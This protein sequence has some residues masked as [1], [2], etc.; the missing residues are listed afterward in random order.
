MKSKLLLSSALISAVAFTGAVHAETKVSGDLEQTYHSASR[1]LAAEDINGASGFGSE[2]NISLSSSK[3]LDN[4]LALKFGTTLEAGSA[5]SEYLTISGDAVEFTVGQDRGDSID[6]DVIPFISDDTATMIGTVGGETGN[7]TTAH[8]KHHAEVKA[9]FAGSALS[10]RYAPSA[11]NKDA[12]D[13]AV[14][15]KDAGGSLT[16]IVL[17]GSLG[18]EGLS[19]LAG[20]NTQVQADDTAA[21]TD[22]IKVTKYGA[23]YNFGQFTVG[24]QRGK[25]DD[26]TNSATDEETTDIYGVSFA[27]TDNL[28]IGVYVSEN[29][30]NGTAEDEESKMLQ[31]GYN[32]G[33]LGIEF[34]AMQVEN[35]GFT[36]GD[37]A[38]V[39]MI[40][41][42]QKF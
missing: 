10:V 3:D 12:D 6:G 30:R 16:E 1:D 41:T 17:K 19:V 37:D 33:G 29:D 18:V 21:G 36:S 4:G 38:D 24:A 39:Y 5:D 27:A 31:I 13:G 40:R 2:H 8:D 9:K 42:R 32:L 7:G 26:G 25:I 22:D 11:S 15:D 23:S 35:I 20:R 28:S 14:V 34:A